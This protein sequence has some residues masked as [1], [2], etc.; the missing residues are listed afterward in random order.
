MELKYITV[1]LSFTNHY[2]KEHGAFRRQTFI[3]WQHQ[4]TDHK[5][6]QK[7]EINLYAYLPLVLE[8][9][10]GP[11][12][13]MKVSQSLIMWKVGLQKVVYYGQLYN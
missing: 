9:P 3:C 6:T 7:Q 5:H 13:V 4:E 10:T 12:L 1:C 8:K 11:K 2:K